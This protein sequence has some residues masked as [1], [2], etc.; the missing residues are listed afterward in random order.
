MT[1][2]DAIKKFEGL[3]NALNIHFSADEP[4]EE[5]VEQEPEVIEEPA[6]EPDP[7]I[8]EPVIEEPEA[9]AE[10]E[11]EVEEEVEV[12]VPAVEMQEEEP[13]DIFNL[14]E[15]KKKINLKLNG[16]YTIE[17]EVMDGVITWGNIYSQ[18]FQQLKSQ[19]KKEYEDEVKQIASKGKE[20][21]LNK[22]VMEPEK[23]ATRKEL[24]MARLAEKDKENIKIIN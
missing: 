21:N 11:E 5:A 8:E 7:V 20:V 2:Q 18:S 15:L 16:F 1:K 12:E 19:L 17:F 6:G 4:V 9:E 13:S 3:L 24:I 14:G 22:R 23:P 10:V